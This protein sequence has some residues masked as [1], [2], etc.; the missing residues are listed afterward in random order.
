MRGQELVGLAQ[1]KFNINPRVANTH[2]V[3][4]LRLLLREHK[5]KTEGPMQH[6]LRGGLTSMKVDELRAE[7]DAKGIR[8]V[9]AQAG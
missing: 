7:R 9:S 1:E 3:D 8:T 5:I 2:T 6:T 4:K